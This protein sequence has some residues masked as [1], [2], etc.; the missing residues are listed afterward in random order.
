MY[1]L[2]RGFRKF[3]KWAFNNEKDYIKLIRVS[4]SGAFLNMKGISNYCYDGLQAQ[5]GSLLKLSKICIP[6]KKLFSET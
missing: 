4:S 2:N 5:E 3:T 6:I 1:S